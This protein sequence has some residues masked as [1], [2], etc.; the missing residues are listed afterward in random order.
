MKIKKN[1]REYYL[2]SILLIVFFLLLGQMSFLVYSSRVSQGE[3]E[4][5]HLIAQYY[6]QNIQENLISKIYTVDSLETLLEITMYDEKKFSDWA[7]SVY[8]YEKGIGSIQL[9]PNGI[10]SYIYPLE[11]N[12]KAIG[13]DLLKDSRRDD[14]AIETIASMDTKFIGPVTLIQNGRRAVISRKPIFR[15]VE[16]NEEFWG[17]SIVVIYVDDIIPSKIDEE[18]YKI[19]ILGDDPDAENV[20]IVYKSDDDTRFS[21]IN[22]P[23]Y[24][25]GAKWN[26]SISSVK[27]SNNI[28][29]HIAIMLISVLFA[30]LFIS[31]NYKIYRQNQEILEL[32]RALNEISIKDYLTGLYN[33]RGIKQIISEMPERFDKAYAVAM[34]DIDNFKDINDTYGH[35][36]GDDTLKYFSNLA[37][38]NCDDDVLISRI[39]GDEFMLLFDEKS[40]KESLQ[41]IMRIVKELNKE[42]S[43]EININIS[44]GIA[45]GSDISSFDK[46]SIKADNALYEAKK[47]GK[48]K[49][50][51]V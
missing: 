11:T 48:N 5:M 12:E 39:G 47:T 22:Y 9:A 31:K 15:I 16:G 20:P 3:D 24:L 14:G 8:S 38:V 36:V 41:T 2:Y 37:L 19:L 4:Q 13:H 40:Y 42:N 28:I 30:L 10:I 50:V 26:I 46:V 43:F 44:C 35:D 25:P 49:I 51:E 23:I 27:E 29:T 7:P 34:V 21:E 1:K 33:R 6:A 32:N 17:F 18:N 45:Y